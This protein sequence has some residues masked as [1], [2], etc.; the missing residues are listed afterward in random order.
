MRQPLVFCLLPA[1]P[2][3]IIEVLSSSSSGISL[4]NRNQ[5]SIL[6]ISYPLMANDLNLPGLQSGIQF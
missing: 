2:L 1:G 6:I 4:L 5:L 3:V